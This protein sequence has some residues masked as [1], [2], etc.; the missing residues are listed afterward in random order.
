MKASLRRPPPSLLAA[1]LS[2]AAF[3]RDLGL[4]SGESQLYRMLLLVGPQ[5]AAEISKLTG[6]TRTNTYNVLSQLEARGLIERRGG[7]RKLVFAPLDPRQLEHVIET[8]ER[9]LQASRETL[10]KAMKSLL[11]D[12]SLAEDHPGIFQFEGKAGMIRVYEELIRDKETVNS[13]VNRRLLRS[14]ISDYNPEYI[15]KRIRN[16]IRS[17]VI[18]PAAGTI[19]SDDVRELREVRYLDADKFPFEMDLKVTKKKIV[20]TTFEEKRLVG[21]ILNDAAIIRNFLVLFEFLWS[22]GKS[23]REVSGNRS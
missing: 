20:M 11:M 16:K 19:Q 4:G 15:A 21:I 12:F 5:R 23:A 7:G 9:K 14:A 2:D 17:R 1:V 13:I 3:L 22:V 8:Q 6:I 18:A 10:S